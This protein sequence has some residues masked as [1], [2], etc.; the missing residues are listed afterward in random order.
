MEA[1]LDGVN[2]A[3]SFDLDSGQCRYVR[4]VITDN[5]FGEPGIVAGGDRVGLGEIRF[6]E[7]PAMANT[8]DPEGGATDVCINA[9]LTWGSGLDATGHDVYFGTDLDAVTNATTGSPLGV[10]VGPGQGA[11]QN[12]YPITGTLS[13]DR[14]TTYYWRVDERKGGSVIT[15][16]VWSFTAEPVAYAIPGGSIT[17]TASSSTNPDTQGPEKTIDGSGLD[18]DD[19]H[20]TEETD[21]WLSDLGGPQPT[22]IHY[23]FDKVYKL[24]QMHIWNHN[25]V[26]ESGIGFGVREA[27]V[28]YSVDGASWSTLGTTHEFVRA[29]APASASYAANTIIDLAGA[30]AQYVRITVNSNWEELLDQYGL[31]EV[32]FLYVPMRARR[33]DPD[34]GEAG[35]PYDDTLGWV[36]GRDAVSHDVLISTDEQD[37]IDESVSAVSVPAEGICG[38]TYSP[39]LLLNQTYYWKVNE[40]GA[41]ETWQGD[42]WSFDTVEYLVVD[43][44]TTYGTVTEMGVQGSWAFYVWRDGEGWNEPDH[45]SKGGNGTGSVLDADL[46]QGYQSPQSLWFSYDNDGTNL[47]GTSG[48]SLYSEATANISD[49]PIDS[50][51]AVGGV[52]SMSLY[53]YGDPNNAITEQLYIKLNGVKVPYDGDMADVNEASWHEWNIDLTQVA[54]NLQSITQITIGFGDDQNTTTPGGSGVVLFDDIRLHPDRCIAEYRSDEFAKFDYAGGDCTVDYLE[55]EVMMADWLMKD[56]VSPPLITWQKFDDGAGSTA[57]DS[58]G[59]GNVGTAVGGPTWMAGRHATAMLFDGSD[60]EVEIPYNPALNPEDAFTV[61][62]WINLSVGGTGHRAVLSGRDDFPSRGYILYVQ[63][64]NTPSLWL[65]YGNVNGWTGVTG[66]VLT[67]SQWVHVVGTYASGELALYVDGALAAENTAATFGINT[68]QELLI[69][70]GSNEGPDH[71]YYFEGMIDDVRIYDKALSE[72]EVGTI[73]DG[74][75]G[76][77]SEHHPLTTPAELYDAEEPGQRSIDF[78]DFAVLMSRWNDTDMWP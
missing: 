72:V 35:V 22:W 67:E 14:G 46:T 65:G 27:V 8:P 36:P 31:S 1:V 9:V 12:Y 51:W 29:P 57:Q 41:S 50:D 44:M 47:L 52:K 16:S 69:G 21:M 39:E 2:D 26:M 73:M 32:R 42:I 56:R 28:E 71:D 37:V 24:H 7:V 15:G 40:V 45:P 68:E 4:M 63:P 30:A 78:K 18:E 11:S 6:A 74:T 62:A 77:V 10:L 66:P 13:L 20:S 48:K 17:A 25:T 60:D 61:A 38:A 33:P 34:D 76:N 53:F 3:Q 23:E 64:D 54:V 70:A 19:L 49:L 43:D 59:N 5:Q 58:S 55:L 75:L